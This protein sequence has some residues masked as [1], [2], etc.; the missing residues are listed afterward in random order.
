MAGILPEYGSRVVALGGG[1]CASC[2]CVLYDP[3]ACFICEVWSLHFFYVFRSAGSKASR[4]G[5][6]T[7]ERHSGGEGE[8]RSAHSASAGL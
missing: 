3:S 6:E 1:F 7:G 5:V 8:R 2:F 4:E